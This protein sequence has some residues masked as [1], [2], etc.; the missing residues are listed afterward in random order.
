MP[1]CA[2]CSQ[3]FTCSC[4]KTN[5]QELGATV[6]QCAVDKKAAIWVHVVDDRGVDIG[7]VIATNDGAEK[8]TAEDSGTAK[9]D[10]VDPGKHTV[11]LLPLSPKLL[12]LYE[13]PPAPTTR[14]IQVSQG[15][16]AYVPY[17]LARKPWLKVKVVEKGNEA[18][19]FTDATVTVTGPE[20]PP[21][22]PTKAG[23]ADFGRV[24]S[25]PYAI[26][27]KLAAEDE[28]TFATSLDFTS[29]QVDV[30][31]FAGREE[32]VLVVV[33]PINLVKPK[34]E[35]EYR[36]VLF[37]RKLS[38]K[39]GGGETKILPS[40][41]YIQA[42]I[43]QSNPAHPYAKT[44][45]LKFTPAN[46]EVFTDEACTQ[47]LTAD[48]TAEQLI[49]TSDQIVGPKPPRYWLRGKTKGKFT[50]ELVLADPADRF[51]K[52]DP[53]P[54]SPEKMGVVDLELKLHQQDLAKLKGAG[55]QVDPNTDPETTY[56]T[57]LKDKP[58]P[59]QVPMTPEEKIGVPTPGDAAKPGRLLHVQSDAHFGRAKLIVAKID[60][61]Q[62]P[63]E[64]EVDDYEIVLN[65][66][67]GSAPDPG[68]D[69]L[70]PLQMQGSDKDVPKTGAIATFDAEFDGTKKDKV[71]YKISVLKAAEQTVWVE[72]TT[73]TE[74]PC[75]VRLDAG[76]DRAPG[77][78]EK[79]VKRNGDWTRY[80]VVK[81]EEVKLDY[82]PEPGKPVAWDS[83]KKE[84]YINL[85]ADS[86][87]RKVKIA[88]KLTKPLKNVVLHFM[89]APDKN[90]K[91][92]NWLVPMPATWKW[93]DITKAVKHIDKADADRKDFLHLSEKTDADGKAAKELTLSRF[94]GDIFWPAAYLEQDA[95]L[96]KYADVDGYPDLSKRKPVLSSNEIKVWRKFWYREVKVQ[97]IN[98]PPLTK[99]V[100]QY[101]RVRALMDAAP[102]LDVDKA[103]ISGGPA[104]YPRYMI[105]PGGGTADALVVS[106]LNR[107]S[108]FAG[109]AA[110]PERPLEMP[111]LICDAM[112]RHI[113]RSGNPAHSDA[114]NL[115]G[116]TR[117]SFPLALGLN[118]SGLPGTFYV[119]KP[120]VDSATI[121]VAGTWKIY[122]KEADNTV[123]LEH[124]GN[125]VDADIELEET[126]AS[127]NRISIKFPST[128]PTGVAWDPAKT[129]VDITGLVIRGAR[130]ILGISTTVSGVKVNVAVYDPT[131]EE[132]FHNTIVHE[133]AHAF[134][135][136]PKGNPANGVVGVPAHPNQADEGFG[137]HC[138]VDTDKCVMYDSGPIVGSYNKFC[139]EC[140]PYMLVQDMARMT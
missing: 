114:L 55:M 127:V 13:A 14:P 134:G 74:Q 112:L 64:A 121:V 54:P 41:T 82:T 107:N 45:K 59:D 42:T 122:Q 138:R 2:R 93:K 100:G 24:K 102:T 101:G 62:L 35:L 98:N 79:K 27:V 83:A 69:A 136:V 20:S 72:G 87:G 108:F 137:N 15:E 130:S 94:G 3:P 120:S 31:L 106:D 18:R 1:L 128:A 117:A 76:M 11:D 124:T 97:G 60:P 67:R 46:V 40:A 43:T 104:I 9:F 44:G 53:T 95:H 56:Y 84:F 78:L 10:P 126:R 119:V 58:I 61:A 52:L 68:A 7:K 34:I 133:L 66:G 99:A 39:Q 103:S 51:V 89:L 111:I 110:V 131:E 90:N 47:P 23:I 36:I 125:W 19:V 21:A 32:E 139:D 105:A 8:A 16:I 80:T 30:E 77:G 132:D 81:I 113:L 123:S 48:L 37:D 65:M 73:E 118:C 28:K 135:Q 129:Y 33:E 49:G 140:H 29:T 86:D 85:K 116:K 109:Y 38:D 115:N 17:Q 92:T 91:K 88:T 75:A 12:A 5:P 96:A 63:D 6:E 4:S 22:Q 71:A 26:K 25:G 70:T 57:N 50:V